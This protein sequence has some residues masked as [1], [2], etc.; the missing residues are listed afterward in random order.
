[1]AN[2]NY[3]GSGKRTDDDRTTWRPDDDENHSERDRNLATERHG[4]GQSGY[5]AGRRGD[6][7]S[8]RYQNRNPSYAAGSFDGRP[9]TRP[10]MGLDDR[11]TG[12]G[13]GDGSERS[14]YHADRSGRGPAQ[15][16]NTGYRSTRDERHEQRFDAGRSRAGYYGDEGGQ[17]ASASYRYDAPRTHGAADDRSTGVYRGMGGHRG[18]GPQNWQRS[19]ERIR[20]AVNEALTDHDHIDATHI[21]VTV[22]DGEVTLAGTVEDRA[23]KRLAEDCVEQIQG[24]REVQNHIRIHRH[25]GRSTSPEG[26]GRIA[27]IPPMLTGD[28]KP[29]A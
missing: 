3:S 15:E 13:D 22:S 21:E 11:F 12:R 6:D 24:V 23:M 16:R 29:R 4:Q 20:E 8:Q 10:G 1:M 28:H 7:F 9:E 18:K 14:D 17:S 2:H 26:N 5:S 27:S 19:D 25:D